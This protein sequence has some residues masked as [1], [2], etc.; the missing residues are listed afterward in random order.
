MPQ[1]IELNGM[2]RALEYKLNKTVRSKM[3]PQKA[4]TKKK[5]RTLSSIIEITNIL[6]EILLIS[7]CI[8]KNNICL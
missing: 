8:C 4:F 6:G 5:V 7:S 1:T 2:F 3:L